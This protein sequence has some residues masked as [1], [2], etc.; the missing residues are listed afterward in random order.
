M[1]GSRK[2]RKTKYVLDV[3]SLICIVFIVVAAIFFAL[4]V[5]KNVVAMPYIFLGCTLLNIISGI[6]DIL[7]DRKLLGIVLCVLAAFMMV[8]FVISAFTFW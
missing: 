2:Y 3:I 1:Y 4:N 8:V 7:S 6:R 5:K